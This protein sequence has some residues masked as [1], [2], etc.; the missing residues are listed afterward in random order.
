MATKKGNI[1]DAFVEGA[2]GG[3]QISLNS[4]IPNVLMAFALIRILEITGV[5][6]II[7]VIFAP[8]MGIFGLPGAAAAVLMAA[9]LSMGGGT[10]AAASLIAAGSLQGHHAIILLPAIYLMGSQVQYIGRIN[11]TMDLPVK[12]NI[13]M[14]IISLINAFLAMLVVRMFI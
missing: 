8:F 6:A 10:G 13:H 3:I 7:E 5:L 11:G 12:Y 9:W 2:K 1:M 4:T 14:L